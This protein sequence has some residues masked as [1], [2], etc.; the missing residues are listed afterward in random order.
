MYINI[1]YQ[2]LKVVNP[3][4]KQPLSSVQYDSIFIIEKNGIS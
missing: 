3:K 1:H 4:K 2:S